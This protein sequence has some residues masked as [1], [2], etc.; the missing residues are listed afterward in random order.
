MN[1]DSSPK[2]EEILAQ[3]SG[4]PDGADLDGSVKLKEARLMLPSS[5]HGH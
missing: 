4:D 1:T 2:S 5:D 3:L